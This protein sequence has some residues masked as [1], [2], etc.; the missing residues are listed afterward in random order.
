MSARRDSLYLAGNVLDKKNLRREHEARRASGL[1]SR[2]LDRSALRDEFG[3]ARAAA[4]MGYGNLVID[5]RKAALALLQA[6][7]GNGARIFSA[8]EM[9]NVRATKIRRHGNRGQRPPHPLQSSCFRDR[10]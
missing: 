10:L 3:I 8:L 2:F 1:P 5:P 4:L 9:T 7:A 6:A